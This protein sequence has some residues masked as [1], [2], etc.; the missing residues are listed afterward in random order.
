MET[1]YFFPVYYW[2]LFRLFY[3]FYVNWKIGNKT[4]ILIFRRY[5]LKY[6][7]AGLK[8]E[9]NELYYRNLCIIN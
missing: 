5:T 3:T 1:E 8:N 2:E 9:L 6:F 7:S 4:F